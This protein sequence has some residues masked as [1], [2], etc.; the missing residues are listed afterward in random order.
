MNNR[1]L[2]SEQQF[3]I[4]IK[5]INVVI[6]HPTNPLILL[7]HFKNVSSEPLELLMGS[8]QLVRQLFNRIVEYKSEDV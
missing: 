5:D 6:R 4:D 7:I 8:D 2:V 3:F 1:Y